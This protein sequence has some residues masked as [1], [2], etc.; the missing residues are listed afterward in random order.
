[1]ASELTTSA[2]RQRAGLSGWL[3]RNLFSSWWNAAVS[4]VLLGLLA[5]LA[6]RLFQWLI[7]DAQWAGSAP[8]ACAD[9]TSLCWPFVRARWPQFL[10]GLYPSEEVWRVNLGLAAGALLGAALAVRRMPARRWIAAFLLL[11]YPPLAWWLFR[12]GTWGLTPVQT[13]LWGGFFLTLVVTGSVFWVS[14]LAGVLLALGRQSRLALVRQACTVWIEFWRAVPVLVLL[15]VV[16][17]MLPLFLP[18]NIEIDKLGRAMIAFAIL[19]STYLAEAV[20]GGLQSLSAGQY[21]AARALGLNWRQSRL[22]V[23]LPQALAVSLPQITSNFIGLFKETTVL[24]VI[25]LF[26]LLGEV[27]RAASD[28][29]WLGTG[30][31][32]AGYIFVAVFFWTACFC[33][34]R[35]SSRLERRITRYRAAAT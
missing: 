17:I 6:V 9:T 18:A 21:E 27:Q 33:L 19:M 22:H 1:M 34:S 13:S 8:S 35:A 14:L 5:M 32:A 16:I 2:A 29:Q 12:G 10:Y 26:D 11:A 20:R 31:T 4:L 30:T 7:I 15:F 28:P 24:L 23:V 3:R 25:G